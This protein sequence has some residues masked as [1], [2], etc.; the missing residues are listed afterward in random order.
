MGR[1]ARCAGR[2][3]SRAT[4]LCSSRLTGDAASLDADGYVF[5]SS[6]A[7]D[8]IS[9]AGYRIGPFEIESSL[10]A[11]PAVAEAAAIGVP[12]ALR[13]E[14]VKAFVVLKPG[15]VSSAALAAE[16]GEWVKSRL[17]AHAYPHSVEFVDQLPK[18]PSGKV[19]RY[20]LRQVSI[21]ATVEAVTRG[22][23]RR[24]RD[25]RYAS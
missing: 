16:L 4:A 15:Q 21:A 9:S 22:L 13:G 8:V 7:D 14:A 24:C 1:P 18:T 6:R 19:Q 20:A 5:F 3:P 2:A 12:D 17:S 25:R 11:H 10:I 23:T